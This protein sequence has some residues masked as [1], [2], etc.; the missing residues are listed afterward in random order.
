MR[1]AKY[2]L[3]GILAV[4]V[5]ILSACTTTRQK[6]Q[7]Q[8][9]LTDIA[10]L[11]T[12]NG[13]VDLIRKSDLATPGQDTQF[14]LILPSGPSSVDI[15]IRA[16]FAHVQ[17][18]QGGYTLALVGPVSS[19]YFHTTNGRFDGSETYT[20]EKGVPKTV[21]FK[22][23]SDMFLEDEMGDCLLVLLGKSGDYET[24]FI[25]NINSPYNP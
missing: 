12:V 24:G 7:A 6:T 21:T 3:H 13:P 15:T 18:V 2:I 16:Y 1:K 20:V 9:I 11:Y 25:Y 19:S 23:K 8:G 4:F 14:S 17:S 5:V 22:L 10:P